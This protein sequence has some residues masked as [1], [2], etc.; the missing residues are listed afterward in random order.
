[1][2]RRGRIWRHVVINTLG[3]W[4]HGDERGFRSRK[5]RIH[6]SGDYRHRPPAG[7]HAGLHD[8]HEERSEDEVHILEPERAVV[9]RTIAKFL[10]DHGHRV[11]AV[12]VTKVHAHFL[13]ELPGPLSDVKE[14]VGQAKQTSSRAV[15]DALPG[16]VWSAGGT[17]KRVLDRAHCGSAHDYILYRQGLDAWTWTYRDGKLDGMFG[18]RRPESNGK[19]RR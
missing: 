11:L 5:H 1:M 10:L 18:R 16:A 8:Y 15:K 7:E 17:W 3:S 14:I 4:L 6:S 12:A 2:P 13:V 19:K 9:G